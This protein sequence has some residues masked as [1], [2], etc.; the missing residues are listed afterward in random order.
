MKGLRPPASG[1]PLGP[2]PLGPPALGADAPM[3]GLRPPHPEGRAPGPGATMGPTRAAWGLPSSPPDPLWCARLPP[4]GAFLRSPRPPLRRGPCPCAGPLRRGAPAAA[5]R[6]RSGVFAL[7]SLAGPAPGPCPPAPPLGLVR[8]FALRRLSL[9]SSGLAVPSAPVRA[10]CSVALP[11]LRAGC[12]QRVAPPGPP[13][14]RPSGFGG[15]WLRPRGPARPFGPLVWGRWPPG[16]FCAPAPARACWRVFPGALLAV[17][18]SPAA[19]RP[20]APAGGSRGPEARLGGLRPPPASRSAPP[21]GRVSRAPLR[22]P[23]PVGAG[24][25]GPLSGVVDSPE[26]VNPDCYTVRVVPPAGSPIVAP[27][28]KAKPLRGGFASLDPLRY[29]TFCPGGLDILARSWYI[30]LPRPVPLPSGGRRS[31]GV[32]GTAKTPTRFLGWGFFHAL[33]P[34]QPC[35][36]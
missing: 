34:S 3:R 23:A 30:G 25:R 13:S 33:G 1:S 32:H 15:G 7:A 8:A 16:P 24:P 19:P 11:A 35:R 12:R 26:I 10:P 6:G 36:N 22:H 28:V 4:S 17:G 5:S 18:L 31:R 2:G 14:A 9:A 21:E 27:R 29:G 20:A